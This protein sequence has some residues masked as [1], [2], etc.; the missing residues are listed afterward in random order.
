MPSRR[1][2]ASQPAAA[3]A[4]F[5]SACAAEGGGK[6]TFGLTLPKP[7]AVFHIDPN[8]PEIIEKEGYA[9]NPDV[10]SFPV[11]YP[12]VA[13]GDKDDI[14]AEAEAAW[15]DTF[16]EPMKALLLDERRDARAIMIDTAT[17]IRDLQLLKYFGKT[18]QI[19]QELYTGPNMELKGLWNSLRHSGLPVVLLHRLRDVYESRIVRTK[20]GPEEKREKVPGKFERDGWNKTG[21]FLNAEVFLF[22]DQGRSEQPASQFGMRI[23]R[24]TSRPA[25]IGQ[26]YWGR[27]K[28][29][30]GERVRRASY[31]YLMT[32]LYP[33]TTLEHWS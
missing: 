22:H 7:L 2:R 12:A 1:Q 29:E 13:F 32:Q 5:L 17:D 10:Q 27:E 33:K 31:P 16:I 11:A 18:A 20:S 3:P 21:F 14:K 23:A 24:T 19:I 6:T 4:P 9:D 28:L 26:E 15:Y 30:N 8:T 25:M